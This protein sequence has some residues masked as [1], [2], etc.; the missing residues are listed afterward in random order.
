MNGFE[1]IQKLGEGAF[2]VVY[3]VRRKFDNNIY[4]LKKVKLQRLKDKEK[5]NALNEV[6]ILASIKSPFVIGY[7]EAFIEES[8]KSLCI[9][10]EYANHGDL[11]QTIC[12]FKKMN[13]LMDE[14]DIWRIFIQMVKGLKCLHDLKILH[15][16][17]KS[18]NIFLF[19]DG[20]AK[21]GDCN[22]SKVLHKDLGHTQT[23][24][25][26]YA[27][28]EVWNDSP[29]DIKSDIWSLGI[30]TY[31]MLNL[32]PPFR[33]E[34]MDALYKKI[35]KGQ[36]PRINMKYS[37]DICNII[38]L[39]LK[40]D[41]NERPTCDQILKNKMVMERIDFFKDRE[42]FKDNFDNLDETQLLKTLRLTKN[43]LF[44]SEQ[45]P[46]PNYKIPKIQKQIGRKLKKKDSKENNISLPN[47]SKSP[48]VNEE[49]KGNNNE[50][51]KKI[52]F[53]YQITANT[54]NKNNYSIYNNKTNTLIQSNSISPN[55]NTKISLNKDLDTTHNYEL[56]NNSPTYRYQERHGFTKGNRNFLKY[57]QGLSVGDLY[58]VYSNETK[59]TTKINYKS[60]NKNNQVLPNIYKNKSNNRYGINKRK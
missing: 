24:T 25:P 23:G 60:H 8:D 41:P 39:L 48:G 29:Y 15:R 4:A 9:I 57:T 19:G 12:K 22:V 47:I 51:S 30:V 33:A 43:M 37:S 2:S 31:E 50:S 55:N 58:S 53:K 56:I 49:K 11:Y 26:Y 20:S 16:D 46:H 54:I 17:L 6:R 27:S 13:Y 38:Q 5:Q 44:L 34:N 21:I 18:A 10:M 45:L 59:K 28:P 14:S 7:K 36:Y 3:K 1:I 42:G 52:S 40:V 35:I 32:H